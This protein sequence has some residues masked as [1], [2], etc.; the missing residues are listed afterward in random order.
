[1]IHFCWFGN[2]KK[3]DLIEKCIKSWK[4]MCP[5]YEIKEWNESNFDVSQNTYCKEAYD[6]KYWAFVSDY[7]RLWIIYNYGGIYLDTDVELVKNID[8]LLKYDSFFCYESEE[9][10][11]TGLGFGA[12]KNNE[13][14][15]RMLDEY[16]NI[17]FVNDGQFD[18]TTCPLRNTN[19]LKSVMNINLCNKKMVEIN[20]TAILCKEF[21][22]PLD[23]DSKK[24]NVTENTYGIH[25]YNES[26]LSSSRR[27]R[28]KMLIVLRNVLGYKIYNKIKKRFK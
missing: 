20:N 24:L 1:M 21:F 5:D 16:N 18:K 6:N 10:I 22:C 3:S 19:S 11:N 9:Y 15:K 25:W 17:H 12:L 8:D 28:K 23:Y 13:L 14:V 7:A 26:W 27:L 2:N 4:K